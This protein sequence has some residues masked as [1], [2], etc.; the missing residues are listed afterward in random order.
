MPNAGMRPKV[1][2]RHSSFVIRASSLTPMPAQPEK[3]DEQ[4]EEMVA[5][6]DGELSPDASLRVEQRLAKDESYRQRLA[7]LERAWNAL[8]ELPVNT[9]GDKFSRTTM[10]MVVEAAADELRI[11][12]VALPTLRR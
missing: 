4:L 9:V 7:R 8:D 5:Y 1:S 12:T 10:T 11:K 3:R 6:L 2:V